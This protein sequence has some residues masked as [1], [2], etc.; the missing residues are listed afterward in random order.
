MTKRLVLSF[1][2]LVGTIFAF[3]QCS[4]Q[5]ETAPQPTSEIKKNR[6][7]KSGSTGTL[8]AQDV[9]GTPQFTFAQRQMKNA[10]VDAFATVENITVTSDEDARLLSEVNPTTNETEYTLLLSVTMPNQEIEYVAAILEKN[11]SDY[12]LMSGSVRTCSPYINGCVNCKFNFWGTCR[13]KDDGGGVCLKTVVTSNLITA[14]E[15]GF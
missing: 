14:F 11:G 8:I 13:C 5:T 3:V 2:L 1:L 9:N 4:K 15:E 10:I 7:N 12:T 6:G